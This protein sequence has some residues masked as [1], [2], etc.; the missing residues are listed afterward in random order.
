MIDRARGGSVDTLTGRYAFAPSVD[1]ANPM[2]ELCEG[3]A[4]A[5]YRAN[6]PNETGY[7]SAPIAALPEKPLAG[8][9]GTYAH[10]GSWKKTA[11]LC[12]P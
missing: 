7:S 9:L 2:T 4:P 10:S 5:T 12:S 1:E 3:L 6:R 11:N 8:R